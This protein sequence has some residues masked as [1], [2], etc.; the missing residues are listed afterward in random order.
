MVRAVCSGARGRRIKHHSRHFQLISVQRSETVRSVPAAP[1]KV[2]GRSKDTLFLPG[3][4]PERSSDP[5]DPV[6]SSGTACYLCPAIPKINSWI[7]WRQEGSE[8][9]RKNS[10]ATAEEAPVFFPRKFPEISSTD[11]FFSKCFQQ[12]S[13]PRRSIKCAERFWYN[14]TY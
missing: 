7:N 8:E 14:S 9:A 11:M 3:F 4:V 10:T 5:G 6:A 1:K 2:L 12:N 13:R